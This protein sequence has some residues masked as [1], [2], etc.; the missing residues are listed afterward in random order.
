MGRPRRGRRQGDRKP[1]AE[2]QGRQSV[3][4]P[5][6]AFGAR[7]GRH[8]QRLRMGQ[9]LSG[10]G[11][12][13]R[14]PPGRP[15]RHR[16]LRGDRGAARLAGLHR[17]AARRPHRGRALL[18]RHALCRAPS[19][20]RL[21]AARP[22]QCGAGP[23]RL[24]QPLQSHDARRGRGDDADR[25]LCVARR[26]ERLP[27]DLLGLLSRHRGRLRQGRCRDLRGVQPRGARGGPPDQRRQAPLPRLLHR[28]PQGA[29]PGD[30]HAHARRSARG[31]PR[32]MRSGADPRRRAATHLRLGAR[33]GHAGADGLAAPP[34]ERGRADPSPYRGRIGMRSRGAFRRRLAAP[35]ASAILWAAGVAATAAD[36][37]AD[38]YTGKTV[39]VLV[40]F[41]PGGGYDLYARM[42]A[43]HLG[44]HIPGQ[45]AIVAQNMPGAGSLKV[46]NYLYNAAPRD[47]TALATFARG[48]VFEPLLGHTE[49][50][51]FEATKLTW[52][53]SISQEVSVCAFMTSAGIRTWAD[54]QT[55]RYV[56]GASGGGAESDVFPNVLRKLFN[57]PLKIVTGYPG[58]TEIIL[59]MERH[60]VDGRCGWS[61]TS[62][63][64]RSK[65]L[66]DNKQIDIT[67]QIGLQR[68]KAL[69]DV[70]LIM[71]L[72]GDA[73]KKAALR[74]I[75]SRQ[76][77]ARPF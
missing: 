18:C 64:S 67:L 58:G 12:R 15:A 11:H 32:G 49:G 52:L 2:P 63:L 36:P 51:Q 19:A 70:P 44:R 6:Q 10:A 1:G 60:E 59:A 33:L 14:Q 39:R 3:R 25:A 55:K 76:S 48:I 61:W 47:G 66:L 29:R 38:F 30:R 17:P 68:D 62:L 31:A 23:Q 53:G 26:E 75:V 24:A 65:A 21:P 37:V 22:D 35:L 27:G 46:V 50:T 43:R 20:R 73:L 16:H 34:R 7:Q 40:G 54:M 57:L 5:R 9:L 13:D 8:V 69:P 41:G 77:I 72:T 74:L 4:Q 56:I 71:D 45:P 28:L 42:L